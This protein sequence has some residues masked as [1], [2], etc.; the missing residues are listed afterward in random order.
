[1]RIVQVV[2]FTEEPVPRLVMPY[3]HLGNLEDVHRESRITE[4]ENV[5]I[6]FQCLD[7]LAFLH[8]HK[9][10]HRDLKP[11]NILVEGRDPFSIKVTD[12]GFAKVAEESFDLKTYC[13]SP[14]YVAPEISLRQPYTA[15]VDVWSLGVFILEYGYGLPQ[16]GK[17][18]VPL[19]QRICIA[20]N[21]WASDPLIDLLRTGMLRIDPSKRLSAGE[22]L[23]KGYDV[24]IFHGKTLDTGNTSPIQQRALQG[25]GS[26]GDSTSIIPGAL[27]EPG[28]GLSDE[29]NDSTSF[30][31]TGNVSNYNNGGIQSYRQRH[32]A[33]EVSTEILVLADNGTSPNDAPRRDMEYSEGRKSKRRRISTVAQLPTADRDNIRNDSNE[34]ED[35]EGFDSDAGYEYSD[36]S[37]EISNEA[38]IGGREYAQNENTRVQR[39]ETRYEDHV[40]FPFLS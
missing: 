2:D 28:A 6:L 14:T 32:N 27:W 40:I 16:R 22:C 15:A 3:Y 7:L 30:R 37:L 10:V 1:M 8:P 26:D 23:Q 20:A 11:A 24:G 5:V 31:G 38:G 13:G 35:V 19:C 12:F 17:R 33:S 4:E 34:S 36:T 9:V 39:H 18:G 29:D 25:D 21:D